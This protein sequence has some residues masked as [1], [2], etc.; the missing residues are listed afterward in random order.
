MKTFAET[1]KAQMIKAAQIGDAALEAKNATDRAADIA[2]AAKTYKITVAAAKK[3][4]KELTN[5][6]LKGICHGMCGAPKN[7]KIEIA[8]KMTINI[9]KYNK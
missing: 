7:L 6:E 4:T 9:R 1:Q 3:A 5:E 8:V 2:A